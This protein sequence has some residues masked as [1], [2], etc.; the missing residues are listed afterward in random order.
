MDS[1]LE[2]SVAAED[3][4]PAPIPVSGFERT[5]AALLSP[6]HFTEPDSSKPS[7]QLVSSPSPVLSE[8]LDLLLDQEL[9]I[10]TTQQDGT[11]EH[12]N[13]QHTSGGS[14]PSS[15]P[16]P[17]FSQQVLPELLQS[18]LESGSR[19][20]SIEQPRLLSGSLEQV[21]GAS[22]PLDQ[23][24]AF[25]DKVTERQESVLDFKHLVTET[26]DREKSVPPLDL[27][28]S[29]RPSAFQVY[30]KQNPSHTPSERAE[31]ATCDATVGGARSKVN[32]LNQEML[33]HPPL[34]WN[35]GAPA[36]FPRIYGHQG[37]AFITPVASNW[38]S[39]PRHPSPWLDHGHVS[40]TP[41]RPPLTIPRS[42]ALPAA[43]QLPGQN[44]KLRLEG[45]V[46][47]LLR[48]APGSGKST[49]A[50]ALLEHNP[51]GVILSTDNYFTRHGVYQF[52]PNE[53]G[54]AHSWNH[55]Q[56]KEAFQRGA[57]PIIIDNTNMQG[58]EMKPYV[59]QA[60]NYNY[61]VLFREPDTWWKN[62][63][64]ELERRNMHNVPAEKIR[65]MLN[66]Y[67]RFVTIQ[68]IMGSQ[69]PE[70]K[71]CFI[72][73][74]KSS[75]PKSSQ[76]PCPDL[77]GDPGLTE[78]SK[79]TRLQLFS[80]LP[81]VSSIGHSADM[82][83]LGNSNHK[84]TESLTLQPPARPLENP[85]NTEGDDD[86]NLG[87]SD[88][89]LDAQ[90]ELNQL[91]GDQRIPDCIVESVMNE[92]HCRDGM[93]VA[94]SE[95]IGQRVRRERTSRRSGFDRLEPADLVKD[96]HQSECA[97]KE[98][99]KT[100]ADEAERV[101]VLWNRGEVL[102]FVG[103]WPSEGSLEQRQ[104]RRQE[105]L[106]EGKNK[107]DGDEPGEA[108]ENDTKKVQSKHDE[109]QKLLDL[110]QTGVADIQTGSSLLPSL[111][112]SSEEE[113]EADVET[114]GGLEE[115]QGSSQLNSADNMSRVNSS[116]GELPDCVLDW[117]AADSCMVREPV[118]LRMDDW[119]HCKTE[120][121]T[122]V[123]GE[124]DNLIKMGQRTQLLDLKSANLANSPSITN[125][126]SDVILETT[127]ESSKE[128]GS[129]SIRD[130]VCAGFTGMENST[131]TETQME[132]ESHTS[133]V[134]QSP[135][136]ETF[137]DLGGSP[138]GAASANQETK[139]RQG[140]RSGKQCKLA[141]TFTQNCPDFSVKS[142][143]CVTTPSPNINTSLDSG[144]I[145]LQTNSDPN[146][147][148]NPLKPY[149]EA[150]LQPTVDTG[151]VTQ[152]ESQD[153]ALLWRLNQQNNPNGKVATAYSHSSDITVI[154]G[155]P[156]RFVPEV[157]GAIPATAAIQL[158]GLKEV[159]YRVVHEKS[160]QV[161]EKDLGETQDRLENLRILSRH[162][163]L[164]SFDTLEDLYDKC[165]L[166]LEWTTNLLLDSGER[167]FKDDD[168]EEEKQEWPD[169]QNKSNVCGV[170]GKVEENM[171]GFNINEHQIKDQPKIGLAMGLEGTQQAISSSSESSKSS[172]ILTFPGPASSVRDKD[173][174]DAS[175]LSGSKADTNTEHK[176]TIQPDLQGGAWGLSTDA[177]VIIEEASVEME[178]DV[179][180]MDQIHRLLQAELE[181]LE[182]EE[183]QREQEQRK[184]RT[185]EQKRNQH[186]DIKSVELK[187]PTEVALQLTELFGPVGVDP[188]ACSADDYDVQMDLNLAKLLHQKWKETIQDRQKQA[189]L[190]FHLL[191]ESSAEWGK[192][193]VAKPWPRERTQ[194]GG[195]M[196]LDSQLPFM[197]HWNVSRQH[198]SLRD[199]IKEEQLRQENME[200]VRQNRTE[201]D[202]R[203]GSTPLKENQ[204]YS[205][206]PTIDRHFLLDIFR[207]HNYSLT[208][209]ELFLRSLL[210]EEPVKTVV[211][212]EAPR[213]NHHRTASKEREKRH[214]P[215]E[216]VRPVYQDP[217]DPEYQDFRAEA[218][219][220][221]RRQL[222]SFAKAAEA[223]KQGHKEVA[224]FY[225]QQGHLHGQRMREA[226]HRAAVQIFERVNASLLP[227]NILDLHGLHVVEAVQHLAQVLEDKTADCEQGLCRPQLSVITGRG[228]H[229]Q[230]GVA[231]I[232]PAVI[233]YLTNK[234]YRF[235]EP[236]PG[237]VLVSLK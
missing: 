107:E 166:D 55:Q 89:E 165:H 202:K 175:A 3:A 191:Q 118:E 75:Q 7:L 139:Q 31:V 124:N 157:T 194:A 116:R 99:E 92:E 39:H 154:Y 69:M 176:E 132:A 213:T 225:A 62:K 223:Y 204:L 162:F 26:S 129:H 167:F 43:P 27:G 209:T 22:S 145:D 100:E 163:K 188:G 83:I 205:R 237:L 151:C 184:R 108:N 53:L 134:C 74:D 169:D 36:F 37:P 67:E 10:L 143:E 11:K 220:Q 88:F 65:R 105:R 52:D 208:Q 127:E 57:N 50:R 86:I 25:E 170:L 21:S 114:G 38:P 185:T 187:L 158:S 150:D 183:K 29:G 146:P 130:D 102:D 64:R 182:K 180:S 112:P 32:I 9:E 5:A 186:M 131:C 34:S 24:S 135:E 218:D 77:V 98:K 113:L 48:G 227:N 101:E 198:V 193:E 228:N 200:R 115:S 172:S 138:L 136:F 13:S 140:R 1:L 219:L 156:S 93:P 121:E 18:S 152:T 171:L 161:E 190:S 56:A 126:D 12:H 78:G 72:L 96:T 85:E 125:A 41:L 82:G 211:A 28:A 8:E 54:E 155:S 109:F 122:S 177:G 233:D 84:S 199:I 168:G 226:N 197:D 47:V 66:A 45:R 178:D 70:K 110:I 91:S 30:K 40:H 181:E 164:V 71:Q 224:S 123:T 179:S 42:W 149:C 159:P 206:F 60:L 15:F 212:P 81:D 207:D 17:Q 120:N 216:A 51:G 128:M 61:K 79:K 87:D 160:T 76:T 106:K 49:L 230:G 222:E 6:T 20:S 173:H 232:R 90:L 19:G 104:V 44:N 14:P 63:P 234:H 215:V 217:E 196:P 153:F 97:I 68:S 73:E 59:I 80:S 111:S 4:C 210:D 236:K 221:R 144:H 195:T 119:E 189:A 142:P 214:K 137:V 46:L 231:R 229:S 35:V 201:L 192:S 148:L 23:L 33:A 103:D 174:T 235:T 133:E 117:K 141:L 203:D 95:S 58:W 16:P 2:L 94:F 147:K